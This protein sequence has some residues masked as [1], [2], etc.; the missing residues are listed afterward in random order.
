MRKVK[1]FILGTFMLLAMGATAHA[2]YVTYGLTG[3]SVGASI[4]LDD[5]TAGFITFT[6]T[7]DPSPYTGDLRGVFFQLTPFGSGITPADIV[8]ADVS[9]VKVGENRITKTGLGN[10]INPCTPFD[11]GVEIGR[12]GRGKDDILSTTFTMAD[13]GVFTLDSFGQGETPFGI[14]MT[15]VG[16][17]GGCR[18]ESRKLL[19]GTFI[20]GG[21]P[22]AVPEPASMLLI[23]AGLAGLLTLRRR[24]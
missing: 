10:V 14:R 18:L 3:D 16:L 4:T 12:P 2:S 22:N 19:G 8:G 7:V 20:D 23:G 24:N 1:T 15:S 5:D 17:L 11:V 21:D 6:V 9:K 13:K